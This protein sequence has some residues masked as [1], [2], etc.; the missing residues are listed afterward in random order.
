[1]RH[2][3]PAALD[4]LE[5]LL[6]KVRSRGLKETARGVFYRKGRAWLHFH[7]DPAGLFADVRARDDWERFRVSEPAERAELL[8]FIDRHI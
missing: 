2:A 5:E 3:G 7:E 4:A 6:T 8:A 1:M